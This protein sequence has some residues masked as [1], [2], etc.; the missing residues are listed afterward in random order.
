M[1][2]V[3]DLGELKPRVEAIRWNLG[4]LSLAAGKARAT[5]YQ[6][7]GHQNPKR[8]THQSISDALVAEELASLGTWRRFIRIF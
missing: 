3:V 8:E 2:Q 5:A 1:K 6:I 7:I 4:D